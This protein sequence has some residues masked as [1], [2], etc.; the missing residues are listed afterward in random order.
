[1]KTYEIIF[2]LPVRQKKIE[3]YCQVA[4][5]WL[6]IRFKGFFFRS[7]YWSCISVCV[8]VCVRARVCMHSHVWIALF[9]YLLTLLND[10]QG[11]LH[12]K[13]L[14]LLSSLSHFGL[15]CLRTTQCFAIILYFSYRKLELFPIILLN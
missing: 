11:P 6:L 5:I 4:F 13:V 8:C 9:L 15:L 10:S 14:N 12:R 1:V 7:L 2:P 3:T